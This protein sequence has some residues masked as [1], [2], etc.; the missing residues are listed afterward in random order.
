M[1]ETEVK[2]SVFS[3]KEV[4]VFRSIDD[5]GKITMDSIADDPF[6][7]Y[8]W[9]KTLETQQ[10]NKVSPI[11]L[12]VYDE[13]NLVCVA[14]LFIE[15]IEPNSNGLFSRLLNLGISQ[16]QVLRCY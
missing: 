10:T 3:G 8:G 14:P 6:F 16:N 13:S 15:L 12:A 1:S 9:F 2:S 5:I 4:K 11:Y 7:T